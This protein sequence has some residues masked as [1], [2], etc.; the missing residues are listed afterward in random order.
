[1][2]DFIFNRG[3]KRGS[4]YLQ[5]QI[6]EYRQTAQEKQSSTWPL[7]VK[8]LENEVNE[9][10]KDF[11][12]VV[13]EIKNMLLSLDELAR[14]L[15]S[16]EISESIY[17]V[18]LEELSENLSASIEKA[19]S[20]REKLEVLKAKSKIEWA[21]EKIT[22][23][24]AEAREMQKYY[25]E[26]Y[27]APYYRLQD[28]ISR[29]EEA[30]STLNFEEEISIIEQYLSTIKGKGKISS[31]KLKKI[32]ETKKICQQRL[33]IISEKWS[34]IRRDKISQLMDL[35]IKSSQIKDDMK[36]VEVR[37]SIGEI[38]RKTYDEKMAILQSSLKKI[39][40]EIADI[41]N[42]IDNID[43]KIFRISEL[44]REEK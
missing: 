40:K 5:K 15:R 4:R 24:A 6:T 38:D 39:E 7:S 37:F 18:L 29:T 11:Q 16:G 3:K 12:S 44:L 13:K 31:E 30:L 36:E 22:G 20:L 43:L 27:L 32:E 33:N 35:D 8:Q 42:Y 14:M 41:R 25:G 2:L 23:R 17:N 21:R 26:S 19:F 10:I 28:L 9:S 1:M 34:S